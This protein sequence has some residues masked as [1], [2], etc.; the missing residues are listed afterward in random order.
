M[1]AGRKPGRWQ[2]LSC[3]HCQS[4]PSISERQPLPYD[5]TCWSAVHAP[6]LSHPWPCAANMSTECELFSPCNAY[7]SDNL[8]PGK[9]AGCPH[10]S[11]NTWTVMI[12][13]LFTDNQQHLDLDCCTAYVVV[14]VLTVPGCQQA[15]TP[16]LLLKH[17]SIIIWAKSQWLDCPR[18]RSK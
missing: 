1:C 3:H 18:P 6:H 15:A 14:T 2:G 13:I 16:V 4:A 12:W 10:M 8:T 9:V 11:T 7:I 5:A 17:C